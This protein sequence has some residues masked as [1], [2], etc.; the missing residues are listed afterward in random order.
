MMIHF[1]QH[2]FDSEDEPG[3]G[4]FMDPSFL[5]MLDDAR[6]IAGIPFIINSGYRTKE[7][8]RKVGGSAKSSHLIGRAADIKVRSSRDR[9]VILNALMMAGFNRIGIGK[10]FIHVDNDEDK[11]PNVIWTYEN[12]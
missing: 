4:R 9:W 2:E 10:T 11:T 6:G 7:R 5:A 8:N 3:S 12:K 1:E